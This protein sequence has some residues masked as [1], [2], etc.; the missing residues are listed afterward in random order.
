MKPGK[1]ILIVTDGAKPTIALAKRIAAKAARMIHAGRAPTIVS[2]GDFT[3][4][5]ILPAVLCFFGCEQ[6]HPPS[7][8]HLEEVLRHI[9]LAGRP[10]GLFSPGSADAIGY[11]SGI[12]RDA[13][14]AAY[15]R[16]LVVPVPGIPASGIPEKEELIDWIEAVVEPITEEMY[17]RKI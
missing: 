14:L 7:F 5:D 10:C 8:A 1:R 12:V 3:A 6:P 2:A 4:T 13:E 15:D 17:G 11:L 16:G 9:N